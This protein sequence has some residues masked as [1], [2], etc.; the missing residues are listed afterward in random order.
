[1]EGLYFKAAENSTPEERKKDVAL[2]AKHGDIEI[3]TQ[4]IK[5]GAVA[6]LKPTQNDD[7]FEFFYLLSGELG[8]ISKDEGLIPVKPGDSFTLN[9]LREDVMCKCVQ[10]S[11]VLY[12]TNSPNY[13]SVTYWQGTLLEQLQRIEEKDHYTLRHSRSV[14]RYAVDLYE[15]LKPDQDRVPLEN[16]I[17]SAL[18]HDIGKCNIP[19]EILN[20][21]AKLTELEFARIREHATESRRILEPLFGE[22]VADF[23]GKHHE[24][25]DGSGYPAGISGNEIPLEVRILMV[26]D[27]FDAMTTDRV[28]SKA[29]GMQEAAD[30][31]CSMKDQY[32]PVVTDALRK[33]VREK[34]LQ[35][36]EK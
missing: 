35:P 16:F 25:M 8:I 20:K 18:F 36:D 2:L 21:P 32:D 12:V 34:Y 14:M 10:E 17:I 15:E 1:M 7:T 27:S 33:L 24:R 3:M 19:T 23:A 5:A 4:F 29:K 22:K 13:D 26:A 30:E 6:W 28:Y 11:R 9:R 31:L